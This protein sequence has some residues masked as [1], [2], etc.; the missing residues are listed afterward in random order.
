MIFKR[1]PLLFNCHIE[2]YLLIIRPPFLDAT[3]HLHRRSCLSVRR[4]LGPSVRRSRIVFE[5]R[6]RSF[7]VFWWWRNLAWTER[8]SRKIKKMTSKC[9]E[10][11]NE[12][13]NDKINNAKKSDDEV[14]ASYGP[15]RSLFLSFVLFL[16]LSLF[17]FL[18]SFCFFFLRSIASFIHC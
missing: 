5:R 17:F 11:D 13:S 4:S 9:K 8:K 6:K 14:V 10:Y 18:S 15:L 2:C 7:S 16:F 1:F 12:Y 3:M